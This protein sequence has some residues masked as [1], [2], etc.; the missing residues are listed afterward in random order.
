MFIFGVGLAD[1]VFWCVTYFIYT[2]NNKASEEMRMRSWVIWEKSWGGSGVLFGRCLTWEVDRVRAAGRR[3]GQNQNSLEGLYKATDLLSQ[4]RSSLKSGS[5]VTE[6]SMLIFILIV[7][8]MFLFN[9]YFVLC[10]WF[11]LRTAVFPVNFSR[12]GSMREHLVL[13]SYGWMDGWE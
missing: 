2:E 12:G 11:L 4:E 5:T 13:L 3:A 9:S 10:Y 1:L 6:Y 8:I 7:F